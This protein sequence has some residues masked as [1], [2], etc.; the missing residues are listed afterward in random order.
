MF[1]KLIKKYYSFPLK[2]SLNL[3]IS[4]LS[5]FI[6]APF[7]TP[8]TMP[9]NDAWSWMCVSAVCQ[10]IANTFIIMALRPGEIA[11]VAPF[12]YA[13]VPLSLALGWWW[14]GDVP[15]AIAFLGIALVLSAGL[16]TLYSERHGLAGRRG[17]AVEKGG[18]AP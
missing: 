8:C 3:L 5:C 17:L 18:Q 9:A 10:L 6:V 4:T 2:Y 7:D 14:W 15:D 11:V 1:K 12:R 16:Y 13:P